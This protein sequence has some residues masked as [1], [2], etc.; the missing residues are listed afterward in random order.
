MDITDIKKTAK[1]NI[2]GNWLKFTLVLFVAG[3]IISVAS[4]TVFKGDDFIEIIEGKTPKSN[5]A[6]DTLF[7]ILQIIVTGP[8]AIGIA[9]CAMNVCNNKDYNLNTLFEGFKDMSRAI[10]LNLVN[11][12][13]IALWTLLFIVPGIIADLKY[14]MST[15]ILIDNPEMSA[16]DARNKSIEIMQG[17][18]MELF[19]L[20]LSFIGWIILSLLTAGILF[21]YV[22]PYMTV[23]QAEFYYRIV[24]KE[25]T[26]EQ[27]NTNEAE[28]NSETTIY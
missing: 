28:I 25:K 4:G 17:H 3:I 18:L 23:A 19:L 21:I 1:S 15:Y 11:G 12:L 24:G 8:L 6:L 10:I 14:S 22:S 20:R 5:S 9:K 7:L 16:S 2:S 26:A 13:L 27:V